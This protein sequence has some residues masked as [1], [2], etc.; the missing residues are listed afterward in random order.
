MARKNAKKRKYILKM[1][2]LCVIINRPIAPSFLRRIMTHQIGYGLLEPAMITDWMA[3][4][5][6]ELKQQLRP[7]IAV[8]TAWLQHLLN[9]GARILLALEELDGA[10]YRAVGTAVLRSS[11]QLEA[12]CDLLAHKLGRTQGLLGSRN[13]ASSCHLRHQNQ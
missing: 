3:S 12:E 6:D 5:L 2:I 4:D 10:G 7:G 11:H 8:T 9:S 13:R 1:C